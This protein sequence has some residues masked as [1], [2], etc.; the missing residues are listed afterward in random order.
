MNKFWK[1]RNAAV[2][3]EAPQLRELILDGEI[4]S[5]T[6]WGDEVTPQIF[7]VGLGLSRPG[8]HRAPEEVGL[9]PL[10]QPSASPAHPVLLGPQEAS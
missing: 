4:A 9:G 2:V 8:N 5:E 3:D 6:W 1:W 7:R 10:F